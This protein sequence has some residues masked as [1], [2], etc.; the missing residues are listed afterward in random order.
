MFKLSDCQKRIHADE[1]GA[2]MM[3]YALIGALIAIVAITT[4]TVMGQEVSKS[5]SKVGSGLKT[6]NN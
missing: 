4:V 6:A 3:E 2:S 1:K 5:F